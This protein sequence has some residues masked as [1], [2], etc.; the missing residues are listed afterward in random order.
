M[1][2]TPFQKASKNVLNYLEEFVPEK[3]NNMGDAM[4]M[5]MMSDDDGKL[6]EQTV[7]AF[8][9]R[10]IPMLDNISENSNKC[11]DELD[12][13]LKKHANWQTV[14]QVITAFASAG[15]VITLFWGTA[16]EPKIIAVLTFVVSVGTIIVN[17][18]IASPINGESK[19]KLAM[20]LVGCLESS[21]R[22]KSYLNLKQGL[23]ASEELINKLSEEITQTVGKSTR[24]FR[25][26]KK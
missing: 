14:L 16:M 9:H 23:I 11:L 19:Q 15:T 18:I 6:D 21:E 12:S 25:L 26:L 17:R 7:N 10:A 5:A 24:L 2:L 20:D 22:I 8:I 3:F 1:S 13:L 4:G